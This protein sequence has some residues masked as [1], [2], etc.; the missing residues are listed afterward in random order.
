MNKT[1]KYMLNSKQ[2]LLNY[3]EHNQSIEK[4]INDVVGIKRLKVTNWGSCQYA[5]AK[6]MFDLLNLMDECDIPHSRIG[7]RLYG[8]E[9]NELNINVCV[10]EIKGVLESYTEGYEDDYKVSQCDEINKIK[11]LEDVYE[12]ARNSTY[13]LW[14]ISNIVMGILFPCGNISTRKAPGYGPTM[15]IICQGSN[16]TTGATCYLL[17]KYGLIKDEICFSHFDT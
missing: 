11:T 12:Y 9:K 8:C 3:I 17:M 4:I 7:V 15:N 10:D 14:T 16:Y 1:N 6:G 13:D 5:Y 2:M